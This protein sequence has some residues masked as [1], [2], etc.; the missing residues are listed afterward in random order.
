MFV[1]DLASKD[2]IKA[3]LA[4]LTVIEAHQRQHTVL[5]QHILSDLQNYDAH[6]SCDVPDGISLPLNRLKDMRN[7]KATLEDRE[8]AKQLVFV[9]QVYRG[10]FD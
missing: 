1:T 9:M 10:L 4:R 5:L 7:L 8:T 6:E 3:V 2:T